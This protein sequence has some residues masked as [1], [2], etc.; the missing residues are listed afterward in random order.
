MHEKSVHKTIN[1]NRLFK[2]SV[3]AVGY[4]IFRI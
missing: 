4:L 2:P 1:L 3:I